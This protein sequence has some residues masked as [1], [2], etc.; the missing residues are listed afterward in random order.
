MTRPEAIQ[1][2]QFY[3]KSQKLVRHH[4]A[5]EAV[6]KALAQRFIEQGVQGINIDYW[7]IVGLLHDADY[8]ITRKTP[9]KHTLYLEEKLR[10]V[11]PE[12]VFHAIKSHNSLTNIKPQSLMD[13]S[14][15]ACDELTGIIILLTLRQKDK[16]IH[17]I[18]P[19]SVLSYLNDRSLEKSPIKAQIMQCETKLNIPINEFVKINLSAMQSI[20]NELGFAG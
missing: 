11:L 3:T 10:N 1:T 8:E 12:D 9:E 16:R 5:V 17:N 6:M 2:L 19:E 14:L 13:W 20:A 15:I 4:F 7:G 18:T